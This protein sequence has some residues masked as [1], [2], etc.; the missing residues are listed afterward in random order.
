M[1]KKWK[2]VEPAVPLG[3]QTAR[4]R[5][6]RGTPLGRDVAIKQKTRALSVLESKIKDK[7]R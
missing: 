7:Y 2:Q 3:A 6:Q 1:I 4:C 5:F